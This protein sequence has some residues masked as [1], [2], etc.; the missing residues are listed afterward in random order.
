MIASMWQQKKIFH[1]F[2]NSLSSKKTWRMSQSHSRWTAEL[3][4]PFDSKKTFRFLLPTCPNICQ[5]GQHTPD[6]HTTCEGVF[7]FRKQKIYC[8]RTINFNCRYVWVRVCLPRF[9]GDEVASL[10]TSGT[11]S[12]PYLHSLRSILIWVRFWLAAAHHKKEEQSKERP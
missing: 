6:A 1:L 3:F 12:D 9:Q 2:Q 5:D 7:Y 4:Y 11:E 8:S 10:K